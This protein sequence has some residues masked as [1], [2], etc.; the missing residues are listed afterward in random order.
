MFPLK[1]RKT[2][3]PVPVESFPPS[4][5][6]YVRAQSHIGKAWALWHTAQGLAQS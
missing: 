2:F 6:D 3:I 4:I 5:T 1:R